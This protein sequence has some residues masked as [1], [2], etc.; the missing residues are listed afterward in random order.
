MLH[1]F[2]VYLLAQFREKRAYEPLVKI[3]SAPGDIPDALLGNTVTE[4]LNR[5]LASIFNGDPDPLK[6]L[7][8]GRE[9]AP[10]VRWAALDTFPVLVAAGEM[11]RENVVAYFEE[12]FTWRLDRDCDQ[13]WNGLIGAVAVAPPGREGPA[14]RWGSSLA[15]SR[16]ELE[17]ARRAA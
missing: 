5:I 15:P 8:E 3:V 16:G 11:T 13:A 4:D 7:V 2:A 1:L 17:A 10:Y 14:S 9:V 6:G 12:L